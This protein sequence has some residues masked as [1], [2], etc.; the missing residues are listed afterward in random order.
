MSLTTVLESNNRIQLPPEWVQ[1]L[2]LRNEV[3]LEKT[4]HGI[5][6]RTATPASWEE[7][8]ADKLVMN[9]ATAASDVE[10]TRDD[11]LF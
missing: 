4:A 8:F 6:I 11:L 1:E 2:G 5:L 3:V 10:V 9:P 7:I